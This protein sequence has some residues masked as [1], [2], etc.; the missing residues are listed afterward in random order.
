MWF[1]R[2]PLPVLAFLL[3]ATIARAD[4]LTTTGGKKLT[5]K[6]VAVDAQGATFTTGET[7][8]KV[9]GKDVVS[10]DLGNKVSP[11]P[12]EADGSAARVNEIELLDGST[13]RTGKFVIKGRKLETELFPGPA[14]VPVPTLDLPLGAVFTVMRGAE[15]PKNRT[16][17]KEMLGRRGKRDLYVFREGPRLDFVPGTI[18]SGSNDGKE[19]EFVKEDGTKTNLLLSRANAGLVFAPAVPAQ[20]AGTLCKV[21]DV[22]GN[23][24]VAKAVE[25]TPAGVAVT[26]VSGVVVK[27]SSPAALAKF[28]YGEANVAYLSDLEPKVDAPPAAVDDKGLRTNVT[29]PFIRDAGVSNEPLKFGNEIFPKGLTVAPETALTYTLTGDYREFRAVLG[30]PENSP[31]G[32]VAAKVTIQADGR[33]V[34]SESVRRKD[35]PKPLVIDIKGV[36]ELRVIVEADLPVNGNRVVLADA[37]VQK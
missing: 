5:G 19:L 20:A 14:E 28:D 31:D 21:I 4:D 13:F 3:A 9:A 23:T 34:F 16:A 12:K 18:L 15:D 25:F 37:R 24:L 11:L 22:F 35:K 27:Y 1:P 7:Q 6:L 2:R 17:W 36:K 10:I 32:D 33:P 8:V 26:T 29:A 30:V